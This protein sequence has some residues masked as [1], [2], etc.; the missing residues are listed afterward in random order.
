[1]DLIDRIGL[2]TK[3]AAKLFLQIAIM[4]MDQGGALHEK[5]HQAQQD[6]GSAR[7]GYRSPA[8]PATTYC[9]FTAH[10]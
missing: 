1:M 6:R 7:F 3:I 2:E 8:T 9:A 10:R 5:Q 4:L